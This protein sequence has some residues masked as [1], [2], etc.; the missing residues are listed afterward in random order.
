MYLCLHI[1]RYLS[2]KVGRRRVLSRAFGTPR[3]V[4]GVH[5]LRDGLGRTFVDDHVLDVSVEDV[6][7][8]QSAV[9]VSDGIELVSF[10]A[11][12]LVTDA[13][14]VTGRAVLDAHLDG[15]VEGRGNGRPSGEYYYFGFRL[16][17]TLSDT[18]EGERSAEAAAGTVCA[19]K[20]ESIALGE[21]PVVSNVV[22][23]QRWPW[24]GCVD[25]DYEIGGYT[26]GLKVQIEFDE[27]GGEGRHWTATNFLAGA[28]PT[29]TPGRNRATWDTT[30]TGVTN[31]VTDVTATVKLVREEAATTTEGFDDTS[32]KMQYSGSTDSAEFRY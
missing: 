9:G 5:V 27:Q 12:V 30:A 15:L 20:S 32:V 1:K 8:G 6:L 16:V 28:E 13:E 3:S 2:K 10:E 14:E 7:Y 23:R 19:G 31:V 21:P 29:L 18:L 11:P 25:V 17:R 26:A 22:A 24:N 4:G